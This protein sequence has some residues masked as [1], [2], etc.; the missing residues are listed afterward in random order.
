MVGTL[1]PSR[2]AGVPKADSEQDSGKGHLLQVV[3]GCLPSL[4][5]LYRCTL[6]STHSF[7]FLQVAVLFP[8]DS[9]QGN[10]TLGVENGR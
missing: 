3:R 8:G 7:L 6:P 9:T 10:S 5:L 2:S 1:R 4:A